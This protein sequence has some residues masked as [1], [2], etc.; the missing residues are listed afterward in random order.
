MEDFGNES[1][2]KTTVHILYIIQIHR[3]L[4]YNLNFGF[5]LSTLI[6]LSLHGTSNSVT[7]VSPVL[8]VLQGLRLLTLLLSLHWLLVSPVLAVL[9][10][11]RLLINHATHQNY[12]HKRGPGS[13]CIPISYHMLHS[14]RHI[15][16]R[17]NVMNQE[18]SNIKH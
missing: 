1:V 18:R 14:L 6:L 10:G 4:Y 16:K 5:C 11:L 17:K 8:V 9:Q 13:H 2:I 7:T 3:Q 12:C 15:F